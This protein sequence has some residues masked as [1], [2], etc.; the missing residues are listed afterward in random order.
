MFGKTWV[1][2]A[3]KY[4]STAAN[5]K[6]GID[7]PKIASTINARS[8]NLPTFNALIDPNSTAAPSH[9]IPAGITSDSVA[10]KRCLN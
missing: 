6:I 3:S 4:S 2:N 8:A 5:K 9:R 1:L 7:T 10:G